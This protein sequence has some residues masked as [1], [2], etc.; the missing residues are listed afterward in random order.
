LAGVEAG[1]KKLKLNDLE[2]DWFLHDATATGEIRAVRAF[3][4]G[5]RYEPTADLFIFDQFQ[6]ELRANSVLEQ[7]EFEVRMLQ[8]K[9][10]ALA[11]PLKL[12]RDKEDRQVYRSVPIFVDRPGTPSQLKTNFPESIAVS[13]GTRI[14]VLAGLHG[15]FELPPTAAL[16]V[17]QSP[18]RFLWKNALREAAQ[19][20]GKSIENWETLT[21]S[22]FAE[23]SDFDWTGGSRIIPLKTGHLA[24]MLLLRDTFVEQMQAYVDQ[25]PENPDEFPLAAWRVFPEKKCCR[26]HRGVVY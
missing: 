1:P 18:G 7:D 15:E 20:T 4:Q 10:A 8:G 17:S 23:L 11:H 12:V 21:E 13:P 5:Q 25:Y 24:A 6:I 19:A 14:S 22:Q 2:I 16:R 3:R 9:N 26:R